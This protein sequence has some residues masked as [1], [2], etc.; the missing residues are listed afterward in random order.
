MRARGYYMNGKGPVDPTLSYHDLVCILD[1]L[2]RQ[3]SPPMQSFYISERHGRDRR[4]TD[5]EYMCALGDAMYE[6]HKT[7][8][9]VKDLELL[10]ECYR[11]WDAQDVIEAERQA[12]FEEAELGVVPQ[13]IRDDFEARAL[14]EAAR[15][16]EAEFNRIPEAGLVERW[17]VDDARQYVSD[18]LP[19]K[20]MD[21]K[22]AEQIDY[23]AKLF[24]CLLKNKHPSQ[25]DYM[26]RHVR[27]LVYTKQI[28]YYWLD[29]QE[30]QHLAGL[31]YDFDLFII[32][33][34]RTTVRGIYE[35]FSDRVW[36]HP[37]P[38]IGEDRA[39]LFPE[40]TPEALEVLNR[41]YSKFGVRTREYVD[42]ERIPKRPRCDEEG[43]GRE[44]RY[45]HY[46]SLNPEHSGID[47]FQLPDG[48][49][50]VL[51][52]FG[53]PPPSRYFGKRK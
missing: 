21:H 52:I 8:F 34:F 40:H 16:R 53:R 24:G 35:H 23:T 15:R 6:P 7:P 9:T 31:G 3:M 17:M 38:T 41:I 1:D 28:R 47:K 11:H 48:S 49:L 43:R 20:H 13:F 4:M 30:K 50:D 29:L 46:R 26:R 19:V 27:R 42:R 25:F 18:L 5:V 12:E 36:S 22:R 32:W 37:F 51:R 2:F 39:E 14:D 44:S 10:M 33:P 45:S